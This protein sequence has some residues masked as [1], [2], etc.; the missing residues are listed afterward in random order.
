MRQLYTMCRLGEQLFDVA[1]CPA[2]P[3]MLMAEE[4]AEVTTRC[5]C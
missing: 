4:K 1:A 2:G 5:N 3:D